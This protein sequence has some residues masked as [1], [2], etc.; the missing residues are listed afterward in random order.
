MVK[1][2]IHMVI[3]NNEIRPIILTVKERTKSF[4]FHYKNKECMAVIYA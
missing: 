3:G 1:I 4:V 2:F